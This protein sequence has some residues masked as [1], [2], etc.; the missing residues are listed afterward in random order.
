MKKNSNNASTDTKTKR[1]Y[2]FVQFLLDLF[3]LFML[4]LVIMAIIDDIVQ[5]YS[6]NEQIRITEHADRITANPY[7][8]IVWGVLALLIYVAGIV[9]PLIYAKKTELNQRQFDIW[10]YAVLLIRILAFVSIF[11]LMSIHLSFIMRNPEFRIHALMHFV[12]MGIIITF[13]RIRIRAA[14]TKSKGKMKITFT[15]D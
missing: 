15:E 10:V 11:E 7:P 12:L 8:M 9:L 6:F 3:G 1:N 5:I 13:T 4:Y 14:A 2:Q